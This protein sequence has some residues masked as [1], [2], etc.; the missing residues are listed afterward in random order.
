MW[1]DTLKGLESIYS[2]ERLIRNKLD[3]PGSLRIRCL[4]LRIRCLFFN[5]TG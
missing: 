2:F 5:R 3:D 4:F 1:L